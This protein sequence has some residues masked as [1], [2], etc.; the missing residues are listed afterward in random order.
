MRTY[1]YTEQ[2]TKRFPELESYGETI[3]KIIDVLVDTHEAGGKILLAGNGGSASDAGH[4]SGELLKGFMLKRTPYGEELEMLEKELGEDAK[5]L[6]RGICAIPLIDHSVISTAFANDC[7]AKLVFA[8]QVYAMG[9]AGDV[10]VGISTSGGA[11]NVILA[12]KTA[13][14]IG[15][16]TV[17]LTGKTGGMLA[18]VSDLSVIAPANETY[19]IQEYH[20]P[21]YH[22]ICADMENILFGE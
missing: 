18:E 13:K 22:A 6:Q 21:I 19:L 1:I 2:L 11:E 10:F 14:A 15:M 17:A 3:K 4:I 7:A 16:K 8:Q 5:I 20:L 9:K 12:A